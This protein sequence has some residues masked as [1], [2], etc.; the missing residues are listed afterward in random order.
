MGMSNRIGDAI[1]ELRQRRRVSIARL[2]MEAGVDPATISAIEHG[3]DMVDTDDNCQTYV[4]PRH[5]FLVLAALGGELRVYVP[6]KAESE[7]A[8]G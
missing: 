7:V 5:L 1:R 2:S 3:R 6:A 8:D 4:L